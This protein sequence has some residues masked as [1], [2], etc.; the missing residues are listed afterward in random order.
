METPEKSDTNEPK[1]ISDI[2]NETFVYTN[3]KISR[4]IAHLEIDTF[5]S[6]PCNLFEEHNRIKCPYYHDI[7]KD[8]KRSHSQFKYTSF[9]CNYIKSNMDCPMKDN[10]NKCHNNVELN[11]HPNNYKKRYCACY[12]DHIKNC[13]FGHFCSYAHSN[14]DLQVEL[15]H[16]Y[17]YDEQFFMFH[18][19]TTYCPINHIM[20]DRALCVYAHNWQDFRRKPHEYLLRLEMCPDWNREAIILTYED[21]CPRGMSC[22]YCHGRK[23]LEYHPFYYRTKPCETSEKDCQRGISCSFYHNQNQKRNIPPHDQFFFEYAP[24]NQLVQ[25]VNKVFLDNELHGLT[26]LNKYNHLKD[27]MSNYE[28]MVEKQQSYIKAALPP[29]IHEQQNSEGTDEN[30]FDES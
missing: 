22:R 15:L 23:E 28:A 2:T 30:N 29:F 4:E 20:H 21:G 19:K 1:I 11:Y 18:F 12:P 8:H 24:R 25:G 13:K 9:L 26:P 3:P 17:A 7:R 5:K 10:C 27:P 16:F 14:N 6:Y